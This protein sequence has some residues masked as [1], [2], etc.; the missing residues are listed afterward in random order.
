[1][2]ERAHAELLEPIGPTVEHLAEATEILVPGVPQAPGIPEALTAA[3][4]G[5]VLPV[6]EE[7]IPLAASLVP[8][9]EPTAAALPE[10]AAVFAELPAAPLVPA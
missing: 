8:A 10:A 6:P 9:S 5:P 3:P 4:A 7:D 1:M 2:A